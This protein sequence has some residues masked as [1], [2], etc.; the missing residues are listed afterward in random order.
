MRSEKL[1]AVAVFYG[2]ALGIAG[3][4]TMEGV[5]RDVEGAG[6]AVQDASQDVEQ[7]IEDERDD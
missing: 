1:F 7:D 2:V 3:C 5:G 6:E 4:N